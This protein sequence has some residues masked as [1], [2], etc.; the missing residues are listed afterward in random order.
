MSLI[1]SIKSAPLVL[2]HVACS[3]TLKLRV[4]I[5][6]LSM[7]PEESLLFSNFFFGH[8]WLREDADEGMQ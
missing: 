8:R 7:M 3:R 6:I 4:M 2:L 1:L 5:L